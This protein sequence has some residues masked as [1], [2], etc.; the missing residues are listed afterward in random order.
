[1]PS[2]MDKQDIL[3][4]LP[5]SIIIDYCTLPDVLHVRC[6][7]RFMN[8]VIS[9][10]MTPFICS[11]MLQSI[12][13]RHNLQYL[14][15]LQR[16]RTE[17]TTHSDHLRRHLLLGTNDTT[18]AEEVRDNCWTR[19]MQ[20]LRIVTVIKPIQQVLVT[21]HPLYGRQLQSMEWDERNNTTRLISYG[22]TFISHKV[23][24][25]PPATIAHPTKDIVSQGGRQLQQSTSST[26]MKRNLP[27]DLQCP[28][29]QHRDV[30]RLSEISYPGEGNNSRPSHALLKW[31]P[32]EKETDEQ[33]MNKRLKTLKA[34]TVASENQDNVTSDNYVE[35]SVAFPPPLYHDCLSEN[36]QPADHPLR[37]PE[38]CRHAISIH[39]THCQTFALVAPVVLCWNAEF[40][41]HERCHERLNP[42]TNP[43][44]P[45]PPYCLVRQ[46]CY[47]PFCERATLCLACSHSTRHEPYNNRAND[48]EELVDRSSP[49]FYAS[50]CSTCQQSFCD[51]HAW[52]ATVCHHW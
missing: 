10:H 11:R 33:L 36:E 23:G 46:Q 52:I 39:C 51:V 35:A 30:L 43:T 24:T 20:V 47:A 15:N 21:R 12:L 13:R 27:W 18:N 5:W 14:S 45:P 22:S 28:A 16:W 37:V 38:D 1:M 40:Q 41:C 29:C 25:N 9:V 32:S 50:H 44:S 17:A 48:E 34:E 8:D 26:E 31:S 19:F 6:L 49:I 2:S 4:L 42:A 3:T 7:C